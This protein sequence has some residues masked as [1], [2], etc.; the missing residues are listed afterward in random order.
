[1]NRNRSRS[2]IF[3]NRPFVL[4]N[5]W[6]SKIMARCSYTTGY[7]SQVDSVCFKSTRVDVSLGFCKS[8]AIIINI[9]CVSK[10]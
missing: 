6:F 3:V 7:W 4:P 5:L 1:M 8:T 2:K 10:S 9:M